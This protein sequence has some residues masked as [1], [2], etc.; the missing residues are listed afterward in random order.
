M[1]R[2]ELELP[3]LPPANQGRS[4]RLGGEFIATAFTGD[5]ALELQ[6]RAVGLRVLELGAFEG[7]SAIV[8]ASVAR[9]VWSVDWHF[10]DGATLNFETWEAFGRHT[11]EYRKAGRV[12]AVAGRFDQVLPLLQPASFELIFH[13]G[14]HDEESVKADLRLALPLLSWDGV[15]CVHDYGLFGVTPAVDALIGPPTLTVGRLAVWEDPRRVG[16]V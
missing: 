12:I 1:N 16:E 13:D 2:L 11:R 7:Y 4:N 3:P 8:L 6:R 14:A 9:E 5:E 10:G 15:L